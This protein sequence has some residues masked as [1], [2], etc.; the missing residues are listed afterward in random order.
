MRFPNIRSAI[1]TESVEGGV[2]SNGLKLATIEEALTAVE[3]LLDDVSSIAESLKRIA[4]RHG[5][6]G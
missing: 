6:N 2:A 5:H 4:D 1:E 3:T